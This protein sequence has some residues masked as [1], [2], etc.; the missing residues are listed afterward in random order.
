LLEQIARLTGKLGKG[1]EPDLNTAAKMVLLDWQKGKLP[2]F[3]T[4]SGYS[5]DAPTA[6]ELLPPQEAAPSCAVTVRATRLTALG[7]RAMPFSVP[8]SSQAARTWVLMPPIVRARHGVSD[9]WLLISARRAFVFVAPAFHVD[10]TSM[11][12]EPSKNVFRALSRRMGLPQGVLD[13]SY[14]PQFGFETSDSKTR[15]RQ[16][17][18]ALFRPSVL[19]LI[20]DRSPGSGARIPL[21]RGLL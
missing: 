6:E 4:P 20:A 3:S 11:P 5:A 10:F 21:S 1:G 9:N 7:V 12:L 13:G 2:F 15:A 17:Q 19:A 16:R 8:R 18:G 14:D